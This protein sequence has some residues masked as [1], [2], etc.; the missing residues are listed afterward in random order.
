LYKSL[1]SKQKLHV[2]NGTKLISWVFGKTGPY[3]KKGGTTKCRRLYLM[4]RT[5]KGDGHTQCR[6][7]RKW[8]KK[9]EHIIDKNN[10]FNQNK[11]GRNHPA[12]QIYHVARDFRNKKTNMRR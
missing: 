5:E 10:R 11:P 7:R 8:S 12:T 2:E 4:W 1:S 9:K 6:G 3:L